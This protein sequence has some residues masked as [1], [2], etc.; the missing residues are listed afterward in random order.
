MKLIPPIAVTP[1]LLTASNVNITETEWTAG[2]YTTGTRRYVGTDLY[3]V[4]ASPSTTDS[5]TAGVNASPPTW[6]RV[7]KINRYRMF[8][9]TIG[10]ATTR[11]S[12]ITVTVTPG[13]IVNALAAFELVAQSAVVTMTDPTD[14]VVYTRTLS[15][16]DN[17]SV[18]DW[19]FYF[20]EPI[21][22]VSEFALTDLPAYGAAAI[23]IAFSGTGTVSVGELVIGAQRNLGVTLQNITVGI[24]DFSRKERDDFGNILVVERRFAKLLNADVFVENSQVNST[25]QSLTAVR[26]QPAVYVGADDRQETI[27]LGFFRDFSILRTGPAASEMTIEIE[28]L[29]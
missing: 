25:L 10:E 13:Q 9:F 14:G 8:D 23:Q 22:R 2:T 26:A 19:W 16:L 11:A 29:T 1:A 21:T 4:V 24:E 12:N 6:I 20:F 18:V 5:P 15:L 3:E 17:S 27:V 7:G 28:G